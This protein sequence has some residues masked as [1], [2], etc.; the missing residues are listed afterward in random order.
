[1]KEWFDFAL[2]H[3]QGLRL[4]IVL[5]LHSFQHCSNGIAQAG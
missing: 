2:G 1:M 3:L 5:A 4:V